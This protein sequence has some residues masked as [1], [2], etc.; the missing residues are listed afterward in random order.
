MTNLISVIYEDDSLLVLDKPAGLVVD[1]AETVK[2]KTLADILQK[3]FG[4]KLL[5]GGI[6]HRLDKDTSG[7]ILAAKTQD[8]LENLQSQFK[9]RV[10]RKEYLALAHGFITEGGIIDAAIAR[11]PENREKF[12]VMEGEEAREAV[13]EY[14]PLERLQ[15]TGDRLQ[16]VFFGFNKIQFKKLSTTH[17][18]LFTF[19]RCKPKTGR[20]HQI[21]V[22]LKYIGNPV[23]ADERYA[24]RKTYRLDKR[25]C[26]RQFLH[27][28]KISFKHPKSGEWMEFES[29]L[30]EDLKKALSYLS[31]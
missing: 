22:H 24:G 8:A 11:N 28:A 31:S 15:F 6:V 19:L 16:E 14:E 29:G 30:P 4:I 25:W 1:P 20:T 9:E 13:T 12:I 27:A 10:V 26:P 21:R 5:R 23:V 17:Y 3:D 2:S 18:N 7:L